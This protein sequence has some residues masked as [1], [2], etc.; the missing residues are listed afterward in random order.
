MGI[1]RNGSSISSTTVMTSASTTNVANQFG[2]TNPNSPNTAF[3]IN[4]LEN[5]TI[6]SGLT[7]STTTYGGY[8]NYLNGLPKLNNKGVTD[9]RTPAVRTT[10]A[11]QLSANTFTSSN[12]TIT[13]IY[14]YYYGTFTGALTTNIVR[15]LISGGT[16]PGG[17]VTK[18]LSNVTSGTSITYNA[19]GVNFWFAHNAS[20]PVKVQWYVDAINKGTINTTTSGFFTAYS[21]TTNSE[22]SLWSGK[23]YYIYLSNFA[24]SLNSVSFNSIAI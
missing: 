21:A 24:S 20:Y 4:Y 1:N 10:T 15:T 7:S 14:P 13:G 3:T 8:G 9:S 22:L 23:M 5:Y 19:S 18:V 16:V 6:P 12:I 11:P 17:T 2:F